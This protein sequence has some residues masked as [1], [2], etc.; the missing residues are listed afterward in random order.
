MADLV[1]LKFGKYRFI[2]N[3]HLFWIF[4]LCWAGFIAGF[5]YGWVGT[6]HDAISCIALSWLMVYTYV[7]VSIIQDHFK[8]KKGG[9]K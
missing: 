3:K 1:L 4:L 6:S 5:F 7:S 9:V 8:K 2:V